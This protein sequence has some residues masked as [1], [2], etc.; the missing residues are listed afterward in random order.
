MSQS[1][2]SIL[3]KIKIDKSWSFSDKTRKETSYITHG[4]HRYPAKFIPQI[5][6]RLAEK[7]T[8]KGDFI[9]DPFGGCGTTIIESKIMGRYSIAVDINPVAVLITKAKITPINPIKIEKEFE[10]LKKKLEKYNKDIKVKVPTHE[11]IDYWFKAEEKRRLAFIFSKIIKVKDQ[12]VQDFFFCGFSNILKNCSI[13]LQKSNKPT[14]DFGKEPSEPI[15][16][17]LRQTKMMLRGNAELFELLSKK[18]YLKISSKVVCTDA[19]TIPVKNGSVDLIVTSPPYVTSYEYADLHQLTAL[20][21]EHTKD[22]SDFR[23]RF[24]GTSYHSKKDLVLNSKLAEKIRSDLLI[25][26]KKTAEEV[27]TYFSEMNQVFVEMKRVL[28]KGGKTCIVVGNTSLIGVD[29]LNAE[30]FVEQLQNLG[31]K[32]VD[33]IKRE[34]PSK[35][36]PSV[37]DEKTGKFARI[38]D[39]NKV[40]AYPTEYILVME[41]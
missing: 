15:K 38:T 5:V 32:V 23:K 13:W 41:K 10:I 40:F 11:R 18:G 22:L 37:R 29:I 35:N 39:K 9:V 26:H 30:V 24:I 17:F 31:L 34:I 3:N 8:K 2:I 25:K 36:L 28:K 33:I 14:R 21:L 4:Y 20:W 7:Y 27:S 1:V 6:S 19:R 12:D 16:T